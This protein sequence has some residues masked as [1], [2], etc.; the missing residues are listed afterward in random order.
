MNNVEFLRA[1]RA[2]IESP[3]KWCQGYFYDLDGRHCLASAALAIMGNIVPESS[4]DALFA[5]RHIANILGFGC[6]REITE[7][8][9]A[10]ERT[11]TDVL[12]RID[13]AVITLENSQ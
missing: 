11:H 10:P 5:R 12:E 8:N 7:W 2:K 1:V 6:I 3:E 4:L 13:T 9:D